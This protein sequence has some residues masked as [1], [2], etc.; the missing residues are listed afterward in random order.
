MGLLG[1]KV[2]LVTGGTRGIGE[3]ISI[4]L[5]KEGAMVVASYLKNDQAANALCQSVAGMGGRLVAVRS[6]VAEPDEISQLRDRIKLDFNGLDILVSNAGPGV[7]RPYDKLN[8]YHMR[9]TWNNNVGGLFRL[10][11]T[12]LPLMEG[13]SGRIVALTSLGSHRVLRDYAAIGTAKAAVEALVRYLA[14]ELGRKGITVNAVCPGIV[15]TEA[16]RHLDR[17]KA[18]MAWSKARTP[19]GRLVTPADVA[20][21]VCFLCGD[22]ASMIDGQI[23]VIDGGYSIRA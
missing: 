4:E 23:L 18:V 21:L 19:V 12:M 6:S 17:S 22:R 2:A 13:R 10:V 5:C 7:F 8:D 20:G 1:G 16:L 11:Q 3:A 9:W 15:D 14:L